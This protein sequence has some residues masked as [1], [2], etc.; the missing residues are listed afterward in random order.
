MK[1][2]YCSD[3][4][5]EF[6]ENAKYI[7]RHPIE[8][9]S[10][11]LLLAGDITLLNNIDQHKDFFDY[12][13]RSFAY[14]Y[15]IPGNHEYYRSDIAE[16]RSPLKMDIRHNVF[17]VNQKVITHDDVSII[18]CTL[19]SH[20]SPEN[21]Y[22]IQRSLSDFHI[23]QNQGKR[24]TVT[25]FNSMHQQDLAFLRSAL[26]EDE[27]KKKIILTHHV[28]TLMNYPKRY[29][30]SPINQA[31]T[32]ELHDLVLTSHAAAWIYGHHHSNTPEFIIGK[33]TLHTNQLGYV[34]HYEY[35]DYRKNAC[36]VV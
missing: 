28:P 29:I 25:D 23:I 16:F 8:P 2:Q 34:S 20:I 24:L 12:L 3:L 10:D 21:E 17:L 7:A 15:W 13:S 27:D 18:C 22:E 11:V 1:I 33:T 30:N 26:K 35:G 36:I 19:W 4:H 6:K 32:T 5:L 9:V 31:F 14:T